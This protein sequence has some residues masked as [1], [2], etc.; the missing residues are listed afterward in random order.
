MLSEVRIMD[1]KII[2]GALQP[3]QY[4]T[5][6]GEIKTIDPQALLTFDENNLPFSTIANAYFLVAR[7]AERRRLEAK[8]L[9]S[10]LD[11]LNGSL[12]IKYV[13]DESFKQLNNGRKPPESMLQ[14]AIKSD[15]QYIALQQKANEAEY[16]ARSLNWL[17]KAI[18]VESNMVQSVSANKRKE[19][20]LPLGGV[21]NNEIQ[22]PIS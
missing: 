4:V 12:Y 3:I 7:L 8:D 20:D 6:R 9:A 10:Q 2:K 13:K 21:N 16:Q 17:V 14:T 11:A 15:A 22:R 1:N 19:L 18:E 5:A